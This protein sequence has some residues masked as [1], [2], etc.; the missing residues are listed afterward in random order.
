M[1]RLKRLLRTAGRVYSTDGLKGLLGRGSRFFLRWLFE[2]STYYLYAKPVVHAE[3]V[4]VAASTLRIGDLTSKVVSSNAEADELEAQGFEFRSYVPNARERLDAGVMATCV[5]V[6][7][8]LGHIAWVA[9]NQKALDSLGEPPYKVDFANGE[10]VG[11]DAW[12]NPKY[13]GKGLR[14]Q[15]ATYVKLKIGSRA[16]DLSSVFLAT[17]S[18]AIGSA[19][20]SHSMSLRISLHH[21]SLG[22]ESLTATILNPASLNACL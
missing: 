2:Y 6:G 18:T 11:T 14:N 1:G 10:A 9:F 17:I 13:R 3:G 19:S 5:F 15:G 8:E 7:K 21:S 20:K 16:D 22:D 4:R 12:T